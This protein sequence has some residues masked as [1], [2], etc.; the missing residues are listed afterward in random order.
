MSTSINRNFSPWDLLKFAAPSIIMMVFMSL[1][2]IVDGM[3][4]S[5][6][7]GSN[8][9]SSLNI[10]FPVINVAIAISTMLG[11]GG[12]AII[13]KYLGECRDEDARKAL[14]QFTV[15]CLGFSFLLMLL[16][17]PNLTLISRFLG[18]SE[19]LLADCRIYLG[20]SMLFAPAAMPKL[21]STSGSIMVS[22]IVTA[23]PTTVFV[24]STPDIPLKRDCTVPLKSFLFS[25]I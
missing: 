11:T 5:R 2:T 8:A 22:P 9:L 15:L 7:V 19:I 12:N 18:S 6:F 10:V 20:V 4:I 23:S 21:T 13:S 17:L 24:E 25:A 14:T 3:F 1:Y 16:S